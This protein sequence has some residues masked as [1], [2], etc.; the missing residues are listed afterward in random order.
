MKKIIISLMIGFCLVLFSN[1]AFAAD[2]GGAFACSCGDSVV[3]DTV[4][5]YDLLDCPGD[6]LWITVNDVTLDC[7]DSVIQ[8]YGDK[9][10]GISSR[11]GV[12][13]KNC[14]VEG[15]NYGVWL[16][17][18]SHNHLLTNEL[19]HNLNGVIIYGSSENSLNGNVLRDNIIRGLYVRQSSYNNIT[20]NSFHDNP[21]YGLQLKESSINNLLWNNSFRD[22]SVHTYEDSASDSF[23]NLSNVGNSWDELN[24]GFPDY[25]EIN[26]PGDGIDW[27][28]DWDFEAECAGLIIEDTILTEDLHNCP[29]DGLTI[30]S[31]NITL[32]CDGHVIDG[33]SSGIGILNVH[34]DNIT[35]KN[36]RV[37]EFSQGIR[38]EEVSGNNVYGNNVS[39]NRNAGIV[40]HNA[41]SNNIFDNYITENNGNNGDGLVISYSNYNNVYRNNIISNEARGVSVLSSTVNNFWNNSLI[42][43]LLNAYEDSGSNGNYWNYSN[44]GNWWDDFVSNPGYP[45]DYYVGGPGDGVDYFP[46]GEGPAGCGSTITEDTILTE[47]LLDCPDH[48]LIIGADNIT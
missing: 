34:Y 29:G 18:S 23:W 13:I 31:D 2:C 36:C 11:S 15:F 4:L 25:Y 6:G 22:N 24:P 10:I 12:T 47:D 5:D 35:I 32:D 45:N 37:E 40:L 28:P 3:E 19:H 16:A 14:E 9:G 8:G 42:S 20:N 38:L 43:N 7:N 46:N 39:F 17:S 48:G 30:Y 41:D 21:D 26:G 1:F 44:I 27:Y 33:A